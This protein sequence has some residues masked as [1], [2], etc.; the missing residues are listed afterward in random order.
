MLSVD[1]QIKIDYKIYRNNK[2]NTFRRKKNIPKPPAAGAKEFH[3]AGFPA[4]ESS[5]LKK[6]KNQKAEGIS[7]NTGRIL[8][9][10][11]KLI[12]RASCRPPS[13]R[14]LSYRCLALSWG[15]GWPSKH[16]GFSKSPVPGFSDHTSVFCDWLEVFS[17]I[18][19]RRPGA[20]LRRRACWSNRADSMGFYSISTP[21]SRN[22]GGLVSGGGGKGGLTLKTTFWLLVLSSWVTWWL[23][24]LTRLGKCLMTIS[25]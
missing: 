1:S 15:T 17:A 18:F 22:F 12:I 9:Q 16:S 3:Q 8:D 7:Q 20:S 23:S 13:S 5:C 6:K 19:L 21:S 2:I 24:S 14:F 4:E 10:R 11:C 25:R